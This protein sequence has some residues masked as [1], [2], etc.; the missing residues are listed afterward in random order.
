MHTIQFT[1]D[2]YN[3]PNNSCILHNISIFNITLD[4]FVI[5]KVYLSLIEYIFL[6]SCATE[7][8]MFESF[9]QIISSI[10]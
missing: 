6:I 8:T 3:F 2:S 4:V 9:A 7:C 10:Q 1:S 5:I